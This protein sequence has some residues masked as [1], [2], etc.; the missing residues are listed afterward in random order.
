MTLTHQS[1][2][3]LADDSPVYRTLISQELKLA[4][5]YSVRSFPDGDSLVNA[6]EDDPL[7]I[8]LDF[9]FDFDDHSNNGS[10]TLKKL[11]AKGCKSPVVLVTG[12]S[13]EDFVKEKSQEDFIRIFDKFEDNMT[14]ELA[15]MIRQL[16]AK[17]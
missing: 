7:L 2:I 8:I 9:H 14:D 16:A 3:W 4:T 17:K 11:R 1:P 12:V 6:L 15:G 5:G 13:D 10:E